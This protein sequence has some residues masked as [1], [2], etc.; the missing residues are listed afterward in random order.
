VLVCDWASRIR[1][2]IL[3]LRQEPNASLRCWRQQYL[4]SMSII[5]DSSSCADSAYLNLDC[6]VGNSLYDPTRNINIIE[7]LPPIMYLKRQLN[8]VY[9]GGI[10]GTC[11]WGREKL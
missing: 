3:Q 10:Q 8:M 11:I 4:D 7:D 1:A 5:T 2:R 9:G 6:L